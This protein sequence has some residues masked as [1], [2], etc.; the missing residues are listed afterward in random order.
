M[1]A[2]AVLW[3]VPETRQTISYMHIYLNPGMVLLAAVVLFGAAIRER[4][5]SGKMFASLSIFA[6]AH[7]CTFLGDLVLGTDVVTANAV[8][9]IDFS[10]ILFF[11]YYPLILIGIL[12]LPVI[13]LRKF[14]KVRKWIEVTIMLLGMSLI[15]WN[16]LIAPAMERPASGVP[17]R[18]VIQFFYPFTGLIILLG[19]MLLGERLTSSISSIFVLLFSSSIV[20][21]VLVDG[22]FSWDILQG[23]YQSGTWL[24][25]GWLFSSLLAVHAGYAQLR[26]KES[27]TVLGMSQRKVDLFMKAYKGKI[28]YIQYAYLIGLFIFTIQSH[29]KPMAFGFTPFAIGLGIILLLILLQQILAVRENNNLNNELM[30]ALQTIQIRQEELLLMNQ[31]LQDEITERKNLEKQLQYDVLH[32]PLTGLPNRVLFM[33]RLGQAIEL[34]IRHSDANYAVLFLDLDQFKSV[35][36]DMGHIYGDRLLVEVSR[37]LQ[38]SLRTTDTIARL[39]GDEFVFLLEAITLETIPDVIERIHKEL[40]LPIRMI[41]KDYQI[42]ASIGVVHSLQAYYSAEQVLQD[43]DEAMYAAKAQGKNRFA[44]FTGGVDSTQIPPHLLS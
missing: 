39:G 20:V 43:A 15:Y 18:E 36:D 3:L 40:A 34:S 42:S 44:V 31:T 2:S 35:N 7:F 41:G 14:E 10:H 32:D 11:L 37:R 25:L 29:Y 38:N 24:Q 17:L 23:T 33:D 6:L 30:L 9:T 22:F 5:E 27:G 4:R 26:R 16:F 21:M 1:G 12:H 19:A 13:H 28:A 8:G